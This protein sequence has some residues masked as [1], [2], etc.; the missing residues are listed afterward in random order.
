VPN[1]Q[2]NY[3]DIKRQ[4]LVDY[5]NLINLEDEGVPEKDVRNMAVNKWGG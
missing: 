1:Y 2:F 3:L 5:A 4:Y